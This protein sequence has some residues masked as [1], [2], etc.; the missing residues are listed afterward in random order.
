M[1]QD[2]KTKHLRGRQ[3]AESACLLDG[4]EA[5][6]SPPQPLAAGGQPVALLLPC[7]LVLA[8]VCLAPCPVCWAT[9]A[10]MRWLPLLPG[11]PPRTPRQQPAPLLAQLQQGRATAAASPSRGASRHMWEPG[12]VAW[13]E[14]GAEGGG[15]EL[16]CHVMRWSSRSLKQNFYSRTCECISHLLTP[17]ILLSFLIGG[18]IKQGKLL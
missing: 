15:I 9:V 7:P 8:C 11:T 2:D 10:A 14:L 13:P 1:H 6:E 5:R 4:R 12:P 3:A 17:L 16:F 18:A